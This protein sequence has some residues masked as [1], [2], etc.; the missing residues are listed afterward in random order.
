MKFEPPGKP[1]RIFLDAGRSSGIRYG[2]VVMAGGAIAARVSDA[3]MNTCMALTPFNQD[4]VVGVMD[5]RSWVLGTFA[6]GDA[7]EVRHVPH[8]ED[9][10]AGDTLVS[11]GLAGLLPRGLPLAVVENVYKTDKPFLEIRA[12]PLY[13][14]SRLQNFVVLTR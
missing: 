5:T 9:V 11:S 12:R 3:Q 1:K 14:P 6:G 7:P 4:F 10:S 13:Q 2:D 8:W